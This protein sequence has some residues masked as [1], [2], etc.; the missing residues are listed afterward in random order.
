VPQP[1]PT[2]SDSKRAQVY[3]EILKNMPPLAAGGIP[4]VE[5]KTRLRDIVAPIPKEEMLNQD[6]L[7]REFVKAL[8]K[9]GT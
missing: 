5:A 4:K 2:I 3:G 9:P 6:D 1:Q 8:F 7:R